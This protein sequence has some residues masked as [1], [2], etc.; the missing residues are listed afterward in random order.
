MQ[1]FPTSGRLRVSVVMRAMLRLE[2]LSTHQSG[3]TPEFEKF[4]CDYLQP[5]D[6]TFCHHD[7]FQEYSNPW[8]W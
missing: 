7:H 2:Y 4:S 5:V 8:Y 3:L 1:V 6:R